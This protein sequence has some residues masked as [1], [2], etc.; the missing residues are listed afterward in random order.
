MVK[1]GS[2]NYRA[3]EA[4]GTHWKNFA[5]DK[6][7][8]WSL[9]VTIFIMITGYYPFYR[10]NNSWYAE[11]ISVLKKLCKDDLCYNLVSAM[12]QISPSARPSIEDVMEHPWFNSLNSQ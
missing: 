12:L 11:D 3:P 5:A 8:I 1:F 9:G 10:M 2:E 6:A 4:S 7:D